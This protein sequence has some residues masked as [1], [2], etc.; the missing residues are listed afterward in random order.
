MNFLMAEQVA[1]AG[2][3]LPALV[4][5]TLVLV[6]ADLILNDL[7]VFLCYFVRDHLVLLCA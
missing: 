4:I 2:E 6:V 7:R 5:K 3:C 1:D